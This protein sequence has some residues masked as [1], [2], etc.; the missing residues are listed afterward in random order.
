MNNLYVRFDTHILPMTEDRNTVPND[1]K[2]GVVWLRPEYMGREDEL[3]NF[4]NAAK[5]LKVSRAAISNWF[6]RRDDFPKVALMTG[7]PDQRTKYLV[8]EEILAYPHKRERKIPKR[9][10]TNRPRHEIIAAKIEKLERTK[11]KLLE[12]ESI[13]RDELHKTQASLIEVKGRLAI[14]RYEI[15][16]LAKGSTDPGS[17]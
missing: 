10:S 13:K 1:E 16:E 7:S 6:N 5:E 3:I 2:H 8:R 17:P 11:E 4:A 12:R 9:A 14:L 15:D